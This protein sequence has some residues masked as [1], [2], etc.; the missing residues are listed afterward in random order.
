[1]PITMSHAVAFFLFPGFHVLD[2]AALT[3]FDVAN[4][5]P[6]GPFYELKILSLEGGVIR[7]SAGAIIES[8]P[9]RDTEPASDTV[10]VSGCGDMAPI[11]A[12]ILAM[13]RHATAGARRI[14]TLCHGARL[15][16]A[17]G[18][19]DGRH[20]AIHATRAQELQ[21]GF[22][23][24]KVEADRIYLRDGHVWS[25]AG[26]AA[27]I[28][29]ALAMVEEDLGL[30]AA[31]AV[32]RHLMMVHWRGEAH[33]QSSSL[34]QMAPESS[35]IR[36]ALAYARQNLRK[37][38]SIDELADHVNMSRRH[39]TRSFRAETGQSPARAIE[40]MRAEVARMLL[41]SSALPLDALAREAGF[42]TSE[43][44]R[45]ALARVYGETPQA[46]RRGMRAA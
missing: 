9:Y 11:E 1:M 42:S 2:L 29:M 10:L 18:V 19:L 23:G 16:A 35:R 27:S 5:Q 38:L 4:K 34:L 21:Q 46:L 22:P 3:I 17:A 13:L 43:Q 30:A 40:I 8:R 31:L 41:E 15:L 28:D 20:V 45:E 7:S 39:F 6:G 32:A 44:M 37:P 25:S 26:M 33:A 12:G 14:G 24:L 36:M